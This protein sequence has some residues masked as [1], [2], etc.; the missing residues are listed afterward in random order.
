MRCWVLLLLATLSI[1]RSLPTT[2]LDSTV[3]EPASSGEFPVDVSRY[4]QL[5]SSHLLFDHLENAFYTLSRKISVQFRDSIQVHVNISPQHDP[6]STS[7]VDVQILK[8]QLRGA[9]GSFIE[10]KLPSV[11]SRRASKL[12]RPSLQSYIE[13]VIRRLCTTEQNDTTATVSNVCLE[14]HARQFLSS[15]DRYL[16][17]HVKRTVADIVS[18]ELPALFDTTRVQVADIVSHFNKQVLSEDHLEL[19]LSADHSEWWVPAEVEDVL[20][21]VVHWQTPNNEQHEAIR[22]DASTMFFAVHHFATLARA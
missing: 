17:N 6:S 1:V 19:V 13:H 8:G 10:D 21:T 3:A 16:G 9:V 15:V 22:P 7:P 5:L 20:E 12:D 11:W 14:T 2:P 4:S 18:Y